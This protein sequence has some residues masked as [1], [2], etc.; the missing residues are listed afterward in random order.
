MFLQIALII[1]V[2]FLSVILTKLL[3]QNGSAIERGFK[4]MD[5][6]FRKMD[7]RTREIADLIVQEGKLTREAIKE[8]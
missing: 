2:A 8:K 3:I 4:K 6:G 7:M 5:E 1:I